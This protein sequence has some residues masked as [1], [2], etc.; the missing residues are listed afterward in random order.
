[1]EQCSLN[2]KTVSKDIYG[3]Q[4]KTLFTVTKRRN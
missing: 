4:R 1:M 3:G 2:V